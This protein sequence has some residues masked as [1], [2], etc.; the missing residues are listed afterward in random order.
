MAQEKQQIRGAVPVGK[1]L[2]LMA[3]LQDSLSLLVIVYLLVDHH[4]L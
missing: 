2:V 4:D 3:T 1:A